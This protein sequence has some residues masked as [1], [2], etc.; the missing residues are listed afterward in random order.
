MGSFTPI[1]I[2]LSTYGGFGKEA[3]QDHKSIAT[4]IADKRNEE[5]A[6]V[7]NYIR[8]RLSVSLIKSILMAVKG[9]RGKKRPAAPVSSLEFNLIEHSRE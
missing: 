8:T 4:L 7:I 9:V 5:Y 1:P 2:V 3:E 6:D